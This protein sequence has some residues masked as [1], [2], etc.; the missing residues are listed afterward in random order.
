M[1]RHSYK[2]P[3]SAAGQTWFC[4][5]EG[6][7]YERTFEAASELGLDGLLSVGPLSSL[8]LDAYIEKVLRSLGHETR[9]SAS[10]LLRANG[11]HGQLTLYRSRPVDDLFLQA[12]QQR[13]VA[14]YRVSVGPAV[15]EPDIEVKVLGDAVSGPYEPPR[16][17]LAVPILYEGRVS[18]IIA[19]A[20]IYPDA[21][22]STDLCGLSSVAA[23]VSNVLGDTLK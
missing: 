23:Q 20:S 4:R 10:G 16:S 6:T 2:V 9:C 18:G 3:P 14:I 5:V 22:S 1:M 17:L 15:V 21:F 7:V 11:D 19:V 12:M 8:P 13:M